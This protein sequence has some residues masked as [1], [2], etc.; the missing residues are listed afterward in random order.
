VIF[1][2]RYIEPALLS[3]LASPVAAIT[4]AGKRPGRQPLGTGPFRFSGIDRTKREIRLKAFA[5]H[6]RGR[7]YLNR[8]ILRWYESF[9]DE[10]RAYEVGRVQVSFRGAIAFSGHVPKYKT[11]S[12]EAPASIL[13]YVGFGT[14]LGQVQPKLLAD[15][16]FRHALSLAINRNGLAKLGTGE[17][18]VP[19]D[20]PVSNTAGRAANRAAL[21]AQVAEARTALARASQRHPSLQHPARLNLQILVNRSRPDDRDIADKILSATSKIGISATVVEVGAAVFDKRVKRGATDLYIGQLV[22]P[23]AT[24]TTQLA[25]AFVAGGS[26]WAR[27]ALGRGPLERTTAYAE[28]GRQLPLIP[29]L[30]RSIIAHHRIDLHGLVFDGEAQTEWADVFFFG[31]ATRN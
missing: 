22:A 31:E 26:S 8:L 18:I 2:L 4:P 25:A 13:A 24:E 20:Q 10:A 7:P 19:T 21:V 6:H 29:L 27:R 30:H 3:Q 5:A 9:D 16:D 23:L 17:R 1:R 28:F 12:V 14:G 11:E 15:R